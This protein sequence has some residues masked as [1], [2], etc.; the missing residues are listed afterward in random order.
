MQ[1]R[2]AAADELLLPNSIEQ[3]QELTWLVKT[4]HTR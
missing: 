2:L 1:G 3:K 4:E